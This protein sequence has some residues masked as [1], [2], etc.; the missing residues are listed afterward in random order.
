MPFTLLAP[1][2]ERY[3]GDALAT[4]LDRAARAGYTVRRVERPAGA[5]AAWLDEQFPGSWWS[6]RAYRAS[7]WVAEAGGAIAG[8]AVFG[9]RSS[10]IARDRSWELRPGVGRLGPIGV[11]AQHRGSGAGE[12]LLAAAMCALRAAGA[13]EALLTSVPDERLAKMFAQ[14]IDARVVDAYEPEYPRARTVILASGAGTNAR[15]V[16]ELVSLGALPLEV[17]SVVSNDRAAGALDAARDHAVAPR[18][19]WWNREAET[20]EDYDERLMASVERLEPDLVLLL[21]WMHLLSPAF[22]ERFPD[23]LNIHPAYLP[24]DPQADRVVMPD[25]TVIP[26]LRGAHALR[27]AVRA[28]LTWTGAS[29][30]AVTS[31]TDRGTIFVRIPL[32]IAPGSDEAA[33]RDQIRPLEFAAVSAGILRWA[34]QRPAAKVGNK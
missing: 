4:T 32:R 7:A 13:T 2:D 12:T 1:L 28:E 5:V 14:R 26:A 3:D 20:R 18:A 11:G 9:E 24:L 33:L 30:H 34:A 29:M 17:I 21:G 31:E 15:N 23:L 22:L 16:M 8:V 6:S 27:D 10:E 19:V 25:G